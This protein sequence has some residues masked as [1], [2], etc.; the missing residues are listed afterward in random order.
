MYLNSFLAQTDQYFNA[1]SPKIY[2]YIFVICSYQ[3]VVA[4]PGDLNQPDTAEPN[5]AAPTAG[6]VSITAHR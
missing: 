6:C 4:P 1:N 5:S 2:I 3:P